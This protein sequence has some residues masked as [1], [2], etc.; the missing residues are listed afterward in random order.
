VKS[1]TMKQRACLA[2][3]VSHRDR[4]GVMPTVEELR[5]ALAMS[6]KSAVSRLLKGLEQRRAIRG[7]RG[8]ARGISLRADKCPHCGKSLD[9]REAA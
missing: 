7:A 2:A 3:I 1:L 4:F 6:S 5:A 9:A 8:R